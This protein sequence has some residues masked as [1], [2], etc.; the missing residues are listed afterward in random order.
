MLVRGRSV[1]AGLLVVACLACGFFIQQ[2]INDDAF[3]SLESRQAAQDAQRLRIALDYEVS[4]L[5]NYAATNSIWDNTHADL[6]RSDQ[7]SFAG[8]FVPADLCGTYGL[9]AVLGVGPGG[10]LRTGG[11]VPVPVVSSRSRRIW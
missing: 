8:D 10:D 7:D 6:T 11:L 1:A 5:S 3:D 4:L 9:D 2:E